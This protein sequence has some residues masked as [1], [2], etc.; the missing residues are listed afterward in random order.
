VETRSDAH[1]AL[2]VWHY[3]AVLLALAFLA[4]HLPFLPASL[5][6]LDS[7]NFAMGLRHF[8]VAH[9]QPH[10]PGYPVYV[11]IGKMARAVVPT[12]TTALGLVSVVSGALSVLALAALLGGISG[13]RD[14]SA[15]LA[16]IVTVTA[17]LY[18]FTA[19]RPLS[20]TMGLAA[21]L[22]VQAITTRVT[23]SRGLTLAAFLGGLAIGIRSQVAW[24]TVPLLL[25]T[26]ARRT[27]GRR[28]STASAVLAALV[29]GSLTWL[30]PLVWLSGGPMAYSRALFDQG[31]EDLTGV[32]MLWTTPTPRQLLLALQG[33][34]VAPWA[35]PGVA[36]AVAILALAGLYRLSRR[37]RPEL[38]TLAVAFGPYL[39]F[40][41]LF[42]ETVTTRYAL[43]LVVPMAFL[44]VQGLEFT[45]RVPAVVL[46][47]CLAS[48]NAHIGGISIAA[49]AREKAP[50]FRMLDDMA[51]APV[52]AVPPTLAMDR[53]LDLDLR[54]PIQ[55]MGDRMPRMSGRLPAPPNHEWL[56]VVKHWNGSEDRQA[57]AVWFVADPLRTDID[58]IQHSDPADY[59][60]SLPYPILIGGARPNEMRWYRI[61]RPDWYVGEG[62]ALTPEAAGVAEADGR[63]LASGPIQAWVARTAF[64][65]AMV[66]GGRNLATAGP[67]AR[68][69]LRADDEDVQFVDTMV[70]PGAFLVVVPFDRQKLIPPSGAGNV[71]VTVRS[72]PGSRVAIEQLDVSAVRPV[73]GFG[74]GWHEPEYNP[75]TGL[76]WRWL[77]QRG[78]VRLHAP[79]GAA[80]RPDGPV[81]PANATGT[82]R[83]SGVVLHLEGESPLR[84]FSRPSRLVIRVG[85]RTLRDEMLSSDFSIDTLIPPELLGEPVSTI[86]IETDQTY[87]PAERSR[88]TLDRRR[89]GLRVFKCQVRLA[90]AVS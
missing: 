50:A 87:L 49:Y 37:G 74:E 72:S 89:L 61:V 22:A 5:E 46:S 1:S 3:A 15:L 64:Q 45:G 76:R 13:A 26:L 9:H 10:P 57:S 55:W 88:R 78:E 67:G 12:E 48:F 34:F 73:F 21:A 79:D 59:R 19:V 65:G 29:L 54:R 69:T 33:L 7:I 84:Y 16:T 90:P 14:R 18:W 63:S 6:D 28:G 71:K 70:Q 77:S 62:W 43:P 82:P 75:S 40:D 68:I 83:R 58:L 52:S 25:L 44:A 17:P 31:A 51:E 42:Q 8:D 36:A 38:V 39:L 24:L 56:E 11:A 80:S 53:R 27:G 41:L 60:W 81:P 20:D 30:V 4:A 32:Q 86:T 47:L 23:T 35:L 2:S 85:A 66:F